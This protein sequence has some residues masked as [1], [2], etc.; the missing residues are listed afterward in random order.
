MSARTVFDDIVAKKAPAEIVFE[1]DATIAF[2]DINQVA[3]VQCVNFLFVWLPDCA[4]GWRI[5][6]LPQSSDWD[7]HVVRMFSVL[8]VPKRRISALSKSTTKDTVILG[9]LLNSAR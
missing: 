5:I 1:D 8:V 7:V 3:P 9:R 4:S 2:R 6:I